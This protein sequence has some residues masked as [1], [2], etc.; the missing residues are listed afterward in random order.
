[1]IVMIR[2]EHVDS[3]GSSSRS[4][5]IVQHMH[6]QLQQAEPGTIQSFAGSS[7][8]SSRQGVQGCGGVGWHRGPVQV[9]G[10]YQPQLVLVEPQWPLALQSHP[11]QLLLWQAGCQRHQMDQKR[12]QQQWGGAV[13]R[14]LSQAVAPTPLQAA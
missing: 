11:E 7:S 10:I 2:Q 3:M 12:L 4:S 9:R 1:M 6:T 14:V 13:G 5:L 8:S